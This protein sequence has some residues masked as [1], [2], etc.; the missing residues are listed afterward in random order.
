MEGKISIISSKF[1]KNI[2]HSSELYVALNLP[3]K[4]LNIFGAIKC[5]FC[6]NNSKSAKHWL[7]NEKYSAVLIGYASDI[8]WMSCWALDLS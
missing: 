5:F 2:S 7:M 1:F 6:P 3:I 4:V 8:L